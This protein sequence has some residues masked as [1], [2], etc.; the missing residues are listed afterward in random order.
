MTKTQKML[1]A[2]KLSPMTGNELKERFNG[3]WTGQRHRLMK[4]GVIEKFQEANEGSEKFYARC[5]VWKYRV[6]GEYKPVIGSSPG[7]LKG[8]KRKT[9]PAKSIDKAIALLVEHGY[10]VKKI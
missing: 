3:A 9:F 6:I 10:S 4:Y 5:I 8:T 7:H 2:L 1:S